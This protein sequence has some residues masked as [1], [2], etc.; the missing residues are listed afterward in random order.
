MFSE[1]TDVPHPET[2]LWWHEAVSL[3]IRS[4]SPKSNELLILSDLY[5]LANLVTFHH[6]CNISLYF[7][8]FWE[9]LLTKISEFPSIS[10]T[11][12]Y[13]EFQV[14]LP[15][16]EDFLLCLIILPIWKRKSP[17]YSFQMDHMYAFQPMVHETTCRQTPFGLISVD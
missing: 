11:S 16:S 1:K 13:S 14:S 15:R 4:R 8:H 5:R 10:Y 7:A 2:G 17:Y 12:P 6:T 3:N 9:N